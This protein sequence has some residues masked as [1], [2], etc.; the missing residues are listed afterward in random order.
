M[1][2]TTH[3]L[4]KLQKNVLHHSSKSLPKACRDHRDLEEFVDV[5]IVDDSLDERRERSTDVHQVESLL[6]QCSSRFSQSDQRASGIVNA[7]FDVTKEVRE[8]RHDLILQN[9]TQ[10]RFQDP[11]F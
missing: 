9:G 4:C 7:R 6:L 10:A 11:Y 2:F 8:L 3:V 5:Y 1:P